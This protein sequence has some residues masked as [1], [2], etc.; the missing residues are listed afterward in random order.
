MKLSYECRP[1]GRQNSFML[2]SSSVGRRSDRDAAGVSAHW[3]VL[4]YERI[5][6]SLQNDL[7][8]YLHTTPE[9]IRVIH[10]C[11]G[12]R[13]HLPILGRPSS[14]VREQWSPAGRRLLTQQ[15]L[16]FDPPGAVED[17][18]AVFGTIS[19]CSWPQTGDFSRLLTFVIFWNNQIINK[20]IELWGQKK[21]V[22]F[23]LMTFKVIFPFSNFL[24]L[25]TPV[26][27]FWVYCF[28]L[29]SCSLYID[30]LMLIA[31]WLARA[32]NL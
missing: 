7:S 1:R 2:L 30:L 19:Q 20:D 24:C 25:S 31:H 3:W 16:S 17:V 21:T 23:H 28:R 27:C 18:P 11:Y 6:I 5:I 22:F 12:W 8:T 29:A 15:A 13:Q 9:M 26:R 10:S 32:S 4:W 14:A